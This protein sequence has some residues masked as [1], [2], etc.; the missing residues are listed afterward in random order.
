MKTQESMSKMGTTK[1]NKLMLTMGIPM[2]LSMVLQAV[3]NI[4]DSA[5]VSNMREKFNNCTDCRSAYQCDPGS[6]LYLRVSGIP[7][8]G[9]KRRC[10]CYSHR[11]DCVYGAGISLSFTV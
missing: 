2:I 11:S 5:F 1:V 7:R 3:Y 8:D 6:D 4:V 9:G 10:L